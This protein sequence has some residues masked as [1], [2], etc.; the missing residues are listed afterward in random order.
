[1]IASLWQVVGA[2]VRVAL[3][4]AAWSEASLDGAPDHGANR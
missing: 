1:M 3:D 2:D 4:E